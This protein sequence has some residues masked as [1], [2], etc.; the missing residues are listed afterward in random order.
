MRP[1]FLRGCAGLWTGLRDFVANAWD[2]PGRRVARRKRTQPT[3]WTIATMEELLRRNRESLDG[4]PIIG[5]SPADMRGVLD[6]MERSPGVVPLLMS[7]R[8][9]PNDFLLLNTGRTDGPLA[10]FGNKVLLRKVNAA[11]WQVCDVSAW[12]S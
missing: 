3:E 5:I 8:I 1:S 11:E 7:I 4:Y 2:G 6:A 9:C 12:K 10:G